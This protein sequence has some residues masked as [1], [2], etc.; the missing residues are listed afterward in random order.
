[1]CRSELGCLD[2]FSDGLHFERLTVVCDLGSDLEPSSL[3][4]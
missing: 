4:P 1:M 2:A 3:E